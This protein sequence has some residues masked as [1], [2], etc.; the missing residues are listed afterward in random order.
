MNYFYAD[1]SN[2]V[3]GPV[4]LEQLLAMLHSGQVNRNTLAAPAG[5]Q[6]WMPIHSLLGQATRPPAPHARPHGPVP[7]AAAL[8]HPA[9][10]HHHPHAHHPH[11]HPVA[12]RGSRM[13]PIY[14]R[15]GLLRLGYFFWSLSVGLLVWGA[16][17]FLLSAVA[18]T[19]HEK[20][21]ADGARQ[22]SYSGHGAYWVLFWLA[23]AG[24]AAGAAGVAASRLGN[25]GWNPW[26]CLLLFVP[27]ANVWIISACLALPPGYG[28]T[29][30]MDLSG[31]I[32]T[33]LV[34]A[35]WVITGISLF[36]HYGTK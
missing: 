26:M 15:G 17:V 34:V 21:L 16:V 2:H 36:M 10:H 11:L 30:R 25:I 23:I 31:K 6:N 5:T 33:S 27:L 1:A 14:R 4:T 9:A 20:T 35:G 18:E 8:A 3:Q 24:G 28:Q 22:V 19:P 29:S 13:I 7:H 12:P 32:I